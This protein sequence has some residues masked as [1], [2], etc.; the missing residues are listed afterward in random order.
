MCRNWVRPMAN[1]L[2]HVL[3]AALPALLV[4][5]GLAA[6]MHRQ[7]SA[8]VS[9]AAAAARV[10]A[11]RPPRPVADVAR[12]VAAMKLVTVEIDTT[13]RIVRGDESWR[14]DVLASIEVPVRLSYG[15]DLS[16]MDVTSLAFSPLSG[17]Y[18]V[19]VPRPT[20][21]ATQVYGE[22]SPP[23]VSTGW[24]RLRSRAGEYYLSQARK[25]A[26]KTADGLTL[27]PEDAAR[28]ESTTKAQV[29]Q[30]I[31]SIVGEETAV[32]VRFKD[33]PAP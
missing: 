12:A 18:Y 19:S 11:L 6:W 5:G 24:A 30:L 20:R 10:N 2:S 25:D 21:I 4:L 26:A 33:E 28:V 13:V 16:A 27:R 32:F 3:R 8:L 17:A 1:A 22:K 31:R 15:T 29:E 14:G 7:Q 23:S 9:E